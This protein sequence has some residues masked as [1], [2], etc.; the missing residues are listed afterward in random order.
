M[1]RAV[2]LLATLLLL[3]CEMVFGQSA[4]QQSYVASSTAGCTTTAGTSTSSTIAPCGGQGLMFE[5][6][7]VSSHTLSWTGTASTCTVELE[8]SAN[9]T[10]WV[11]MSGSAVQTCTTAG[12]YTF[13]VSPAGSLPVYVRF[14]V[15]SLTTTG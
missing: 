6:S 11:I 2:L 10:T 3:T 8:T 15:L 9:G 4:F 14:N 13:V 5:N 1:K 12:N 7:T